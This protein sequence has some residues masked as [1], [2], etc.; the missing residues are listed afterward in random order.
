MSTNEKYQAIAKEKQHE[1]NL[2]DSSIRP[3]FIRDIPWG[4]DGSIVY[5][6]WGTD[7]RDF[8]R[9]RIAIPENSTPAE[10]AAIFRQL[11]DQLEAGKGKMICRGEELFE[12]AP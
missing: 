1:F 12:D 3:T 10:A 6:T 2:K 9:A 4:Y 8:F 7:P 11:A 5:L